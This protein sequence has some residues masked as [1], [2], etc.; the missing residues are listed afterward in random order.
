MAMELARAAGAAIL[1]LFR[2]DH[3]LEDKGAAKGQAFDPV[4]AADRGAEAAIRQVIA[5]RCPDHGVLGEEYGED[6]V[7]AE[8][9]WVLDPIDGTRGFIAGIPLWTTLIA[10]RW[11]GE[12]VVGLIAQPYLDEIFLG[13]ALGSRLIRP[14]GTRQLAVR[15]CPGLGSAIVGVTDPLAYFTPLEQTAFSRVRDAARLTR[16]GGD[17]YFFA[18][19]ALGVLD[20]VVEPTA[21]KAWDVEAAIPLIQGAGG[22][23]TDWRGR[24][25]GRDGGQIVAAGDRACLDETLALL[26][27]AAV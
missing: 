1:P 25:I 8:F 21:L 6:R 12:P 9:V 17:A 15:A 24:P 11:R 23:V 22:F 4:T 5:E 7:D 3:G 26:A 20:V 18:L 16:L 10:L 19:T 13:T 27:Y 14:D 2:A